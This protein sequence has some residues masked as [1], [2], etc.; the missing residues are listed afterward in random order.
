LEWKTLTGFQIACE[1]LK[2]FGHWFLFSVAIALAQLWLIPFGYYLA[3]KPWTWVDLVGN[4]SLLFFATTI[5]SKTA[6][7]YFKRVKRRS[8]VATL[9]CIGMTLII[10]F[11][12]VFA[13][14][15]VISSRIGLLGANLA[16]ERVAT[17]SDML[18]LSSLIFSAA[19]TLIIRV[20]AE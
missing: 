1:V 11:L 20:S 19:F 17:S 6:G 9:F 4:G 15:L 2:E 8:D 16:P 18:A 12:S 10:V 5:T 13:Y 14:T 3:K 7:E